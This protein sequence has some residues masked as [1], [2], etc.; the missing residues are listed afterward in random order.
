MCGLLLAQGDTTGW[1]VAGATLLT[2]LVAATGGAVV[3]ILVSRSNQRI[4]EAESRAKIDADARAGTVQEWRELTHATQER[5]EAQQ[6]RHDEQVVAWQKQHGELSERVYALHQTNAECE[7]DRA[8]QAG[9]I[10]L[11]QAAVQRLQAQAGDTLPAVSAAVILADTEGTLRVV[12]PAISL[13]LHWHPAELVG[14][15][16]E[17]VIPE[18]FRAAHREGLARFRATGTPP[19]TERVISTFAL[20]GDG[21]EVP[22]AVTLSGWQSVKGE[23]FVSAEVRRRVLPPA[24]AGGGGAS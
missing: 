12:S 13:I 15:N 1:W 17:K 21:S 2:A 4:K 10:R 5:F 6:Q 24:A 23:W 14:K 16:V 18:R 9:E 7:K 22:V 11:L 3:S 20:T 8:G 19:W